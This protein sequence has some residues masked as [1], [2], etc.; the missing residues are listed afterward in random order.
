MNSFKFNTKTWPLYHAMHSLP[1]PNGDE[2][3]LNEAII[4]STTLTRLQSSECFTRET[5]TSYLSVKGFSSEKVWVCA[6]ERRHVLK[7]KNRG[8]TQ[9]R[10][11]TLLSLPFFWGDLHYLSGLLPFLTGKKI[12]SAHPEPIIYEIGTCF[13]SNLP[14]KC[15]G[16]IWWFLLVNH[17]SS[18]S[19]SSSSS[20]LSLT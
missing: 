20:S 7:S 16:L 1:F 18:S 13:Y 8:S 12:V 17:Q 4:W 10:H 6:I 14:L 2:M 3:F 19:S 15:L 5:V 9:K 11:E